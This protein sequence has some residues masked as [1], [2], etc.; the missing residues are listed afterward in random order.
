MTILQSQN[1][2]AHYSRDALRWGLVISMSSDR[3]GYPPKDKVINSIKDVG[4]T[5]LRNP[6]NNVTQQGS[7]QA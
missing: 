1:H 4:E 5:S 7:D 3:G 2:G 6:G